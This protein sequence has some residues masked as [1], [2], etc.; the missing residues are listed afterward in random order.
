MPKQ[1]VDLEEELKEKLEAI[2]PEHQFRTSLI[3]EAMV[4][5]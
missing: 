5:S 2:T 3:D 4:A 1:T